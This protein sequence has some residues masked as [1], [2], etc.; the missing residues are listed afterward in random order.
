MAAKSAGRAGLIAAIVIVGAL[1][2]L[3]WRTAAHPGVRP[4]AAGVVFLDDNG[5]GRRGVGEAGIAGVGVSDGRHISVTDALGRYALP[6]REDATFFV[7]KPAG[8]SVPL[9][10][11]NLPQFYYHHR[12]GG[13]PDTEY[14]G[15]APTGRIPHPLNFAMQ[16]S[17]Q[18]ESFQVL[19][20]ADPQPRDQ[21]EVD[22]VRRDVLEPLAGSPALFGIT[23]GDIMFDDLSLFESMNTAIAGIG[24]PWYNVVGNHDLNMDVS[25]DHESVETFRRYFGPNYY[26]FDYGPAHFLVLDNVSWKADP[27]GFDGQLDEE[28]LEFVRNDLA[29]IPPDRPLVIFMHVPLDEVGN[30]SELFRLIEDRPLCVSV[31]GHTHFMDHRFLDEEHG[32][33]GAEPHHHIVN[34]TVS[35]SWWSGA[36]DDAG[37]PHAT[38]NDG[39]PNGYG[40]LTISADSYRYEY[41]SADE[42]PEH[43]MRIH[44]PSQVSQ[45]REDPAQYYVNVFGGS[46]RSRVELRVGDGRWRRLRRVQ[47]AD[48]AYV[49]LFERDRELE[50]PYRSLPHPRNSTHLWRWTMPRNLAPGTHMLELRSTDLFGHVVTGRHEVVVSPD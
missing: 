34:V 41:R 3:V 35:G 18:P 24:I 49:E 27:P 17:A 4:W 11:E 20:L 46:E 44:G 22:Y 47:Q 10:A 42:G 31:S 50:A 15:I 16:R 25:S 37:I 26:S 19:L 14:P 43:Q 5:D 45:S 32:W 12:P 40:V 7:I 48:P 28:Q 29:L 38:M 39:S 2:L 1:L 21:L 30:R 6:A 8:F 9:N 13:S 23:L 36:A 33:Q